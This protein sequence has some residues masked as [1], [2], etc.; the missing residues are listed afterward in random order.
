MNALVA[1]AFNTFRETI[2]NKV[3]YNILLFAAIVIALSV[4]FGEWSVFARI[5]VMQDFGLATMSLSGLLLAVFI[6]VAL[7]GRE[8]NTRTVHLMA[9]KPIPRHLIVVGKFAGLSTTLLLNLALMT[10]FL[11]LTLLAIGGSV[12]P[13]LMV[14]A[15]LIMCEMLVIVAV[16]L[17]F[18]TITTSTPAAI[19]TIAFYITG[20]LN[21]LLDI[22]K[23]PESQ[24]LLA[25]GLRVVYYV[26]PNLEHFNV[27]TA[28]VYGMPL[29]AGYV[30]FALLYGILYT[31]LL[32]LLSC[33]LFSRR[34]L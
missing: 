10:V 18:S 13:N 34:D 30:L 3:L 9:A 6:G 7:L 26:L 15:A 25:W 20:H 21:D 24:S 1:I 32:L 33:C 27:R 16:A 22:D 4:S 14:A 17:F 23:V 12:Q 2:R 8:V 5:Q 31:A 11:F 19:L 29:S 28:V